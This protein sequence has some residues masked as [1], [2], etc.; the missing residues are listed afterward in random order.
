MI[1]YMYLLPLLAI[2]NSGLERAKSILQA[3]NQQIAPVSVNIVSPMVF[4]T[5]YQTAAT[6]EG[7]FCKANGKKNKRN[8]KRSLCPK[9]KGYSAEF[10]IS[11][12]PKTYVSIQLD[13]DEYK[14]GLKFS[15]DSKTTKLEQRVRIKKDGFGTF[16]A[17]GVITLQDTQA[18]SSGEYAFSLYVTALYQ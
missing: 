1:S 7:A 4:P 17:G 14:Q 2:N 10:E 6:K 12:K 9:M 16:F 3:S 5:L 18:T 8:A 11:G 15:I 13:A